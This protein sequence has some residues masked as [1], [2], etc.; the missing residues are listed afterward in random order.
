MGGREEE[1]GA[2]DGARTELGERVVTGQG[3]DEIGITDGGTLET[4]ISSTS[5]G[6]SFM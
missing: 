5:Q 6:F 2:L 4:L 1:R 3:R